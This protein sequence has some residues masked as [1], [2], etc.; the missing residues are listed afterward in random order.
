MIEE[1]K[2]LEAVLVELRRSGEAE[3]AAI[4][5]MLEEIAARGGSQARRD[6]LILCLQELK[7]WADYAIAKLQK[8][9]D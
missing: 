4:A 8:G 3:P 2:F 1:D 7:G 5:A 9:V 6:Y